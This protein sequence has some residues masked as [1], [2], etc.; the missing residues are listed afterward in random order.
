MAKPSSLKET[1]ARHPYLFGNKDLPIPEEHGRLS[2]KKS[3]SS[4]CLLTLNDRTFLSSERLEG[5]DMNGLI[6][7]YVIP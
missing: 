6:D 1:I 3:V 2:A 4:E 5:A 7:R